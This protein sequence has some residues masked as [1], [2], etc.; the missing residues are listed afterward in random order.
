MVE[1][2]DGEQQFSVSVGPGLEFPQSLSAAAPCSLQ[3]KNN[4]SLCKKA[5][6]HSF[7]QPV[8]G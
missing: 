1:G 5:H 2:N 3:E 4:G 6:T 7:T 8:W